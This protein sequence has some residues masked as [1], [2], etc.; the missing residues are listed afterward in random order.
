[1]DSPLFAQRAVRCIP[2][3]DEKLRAL[4]EAA[5]AETDG[6]PVEAVEF[7]V[8]QVVKASYP[9]AA[10]VPMDPIAATADEE[11]WYV[12]RDGCPSR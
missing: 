2:T 8:A 3:S 4:A 12:Y 6:L 9:A 1:M 5:L 10:V 7:L 11:V